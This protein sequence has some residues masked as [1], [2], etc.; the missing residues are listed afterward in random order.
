MSLKRNITVNKYDNEKEIHDSDFG[1]I[2]PGF[3]IYPT[4]IEHK[5]RVIAIGDIH[6]DMNL[7][8]DFLMAA[9]VIKEVSN[10]TERS[11]EKI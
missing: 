7:A 4:I 8:I 3:D 10:D 5:R 11:R 6:G 1:E 9:K 2:C